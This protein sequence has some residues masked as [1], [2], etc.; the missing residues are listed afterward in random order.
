MAI[1]QGQGRAYAKVN[2]HLQV[3]EQRADGFHNLLSLFQ[4]IDFYD[5]LKVTVTP[6]TSF[7]CSIEGTPRVPLLEN[8]LY[9]SAEH[10]YRSLEQ[11]AKLEIEINKQIP[12]QAGLG[13]GSSDAACL[14]HIL[15]QIHNQALSHGMLWEIALK[16]GSDVPFFLSQAATAIVTGR[17]EEV[18]PIQARSDLCALLITRVQEPVSTKQAF[19]MLSQERFTQGRLLKQELNSLYHQPS[20]SW[21]FKNDFYREDQRYRAFQAASAAHGSP[22]GTLS[23]S[24]SAFVIISEQREQLERIK[25]ELTLLSG[26]VAQIVDCLS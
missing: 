22:F 17:G 15:N 16:V 1:K 3:E 14:L 8:T 25:R 9:L 20:A 18:A 11:S 7:H 24:G 5:E 21:P 13:G 2:L 19:A 10:F 23:G 26:E 4:L 6:A 12:A